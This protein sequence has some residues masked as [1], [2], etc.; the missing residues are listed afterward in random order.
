MRRPF[1]GPLPLQIRMPQKTHTHTKEKKSKSLDQLYNLE[2]ATS[3]VCL[4]TAWRNKTLL[5]TP[6]K[7][8]EK[9]F[10]N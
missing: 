10:A 1:S 5:V 2:T 6:K 7:K 3:Y 8:F 9:I 4:S